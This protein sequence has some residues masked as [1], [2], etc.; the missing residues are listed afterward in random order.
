MTYVSNGKTKTHVRLSNWTLGSNNKSFGK[1]KL[2]LVSAR[3][4]VRLQRGLD[5]RLVCIAVMSRFPLNS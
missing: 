3:P 2:P 1:T 4:A 5:I